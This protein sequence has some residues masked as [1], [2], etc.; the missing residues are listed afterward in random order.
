MRAVSIASLNPLRLLDRFQS[1]PYEKLPGFEPS[2]E[3]SPTSPGAGKRKGWLLPKAG[4]GRSCK[5]WVRILA[6]VLVVIA[7]LGYLGGGHYQRQQE[8]QQE[9]EKAVEEHAN[10]KFWEVFPRYLYNIASLS[11]VYR[12]G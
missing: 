11:V 8:E 2:Q 9:E 6:C 10:T 1:P 3:A 12:F 5:N 4:A 7:F